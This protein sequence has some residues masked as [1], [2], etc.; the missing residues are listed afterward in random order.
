MIDLMFI[1]NISRLDTIKFNN[2]AERESYFS[3]RSIVTI[4]SIY[5]PHFQNRIQ[6]SIEDLSPS[7]KVNYL[8]LYYEGKYY[9]YFIDNINYINQGLYELIITMDTITTFMFDLTINKAILERYS[10]NRWNKD[11]TINRNYI[12]ENLSNSNFKLDVY[13][14]IKN[15]PLNNSTN[16]DITP[17]IL[18]QRR[19]KLNNEQAV[20][21]AGTFYDEDDFSSKI[22]FDNFI[23]DNNS[24]VIDD[25]SIYYLFPLLKN[26]YETISFGR[27]RSNDTINNLNR[28]DY[29]YYLNKLLEDLNTVNA[30]LINNDVL[31]QLIY[32][33]D[34]VNNFGNTV[35]DFNSYSSNVN[36]VYPVRYTIS[37]GSGVGE[38]RSACFRLKRLTIFHYDNIYTMKIN[39]SYFSKN[40][41]INEPFNISFIPQLIDEN[42]FHIYY[43]ENVEYTTFPLHMLTNTSLRLEKLYDILTNNRIYRIKDLY[44]NSIYDKHFTTLIIQTKEEVQLYKDALT[45]YMQ[46]NKGSLTMGVALAKRNAQLD[47]A[48]DIIG[49][50]SHKSKKPKYLD[51]GNNLIDLYQD[52]YNI[53]E[54]IRI[55]KTNAEY[56]PDTTRQGNSFSSDLT[57]YSLENIIL[58]ESVDDLEYIGKKYEQYGYL[59]NKEVL[60]KRLYLDFNERY[61][62]NIVKFNN[63]DIELN[64]INSSKLKFDI[65]ERLTNG[66]RLWNIINIYNSEHINFSLFEYDNIENSFIE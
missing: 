38:I 53:D 40:V 29:Y 21:N 54:R 14:I 37:S 41:N 27:Y 47:F 65:I 26:N 43:G 25:G 46:T 16:N 8:S 30:F 22:S 58:Q 10:I 28:N 7:T 3:S 20:D 32:V 24:E 2:S 45:N 39:N 18:I 23:G 15:S 35:I 31:N 66:V 9:Y 6:F 62:F 63:V 57:A 17:C 33:S 55:N 48:Q 13:D 1:K 52:I 51:M 11:N 19:A 34:H 12:R 50:G 49:I 56:T 64:Y 59:V 4:D 44:D 60:N 42:Y 61:Y 36:K 5:P